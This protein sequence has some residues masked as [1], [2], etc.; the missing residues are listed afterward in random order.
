M[1]MSL[2]QERIGARDQAPGES[3]AQL[4]ASGQGF[5][6]RC[7]RI[8]GGGTKMLDDTAGFRAWEKPR[9]PLI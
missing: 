1:R 2:Q 5:N 6:R 9:F 7:L 8:V 4:A 3:A